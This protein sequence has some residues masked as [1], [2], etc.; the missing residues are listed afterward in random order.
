MRGL[1]ARSHLFTSTE[2]PVAGAV[3]RPPT[4]WHSVFSLCSRGGGRG[5]LS[6]SVTGAYIHMRHGN[7]ILKT[8]CV[9]LTQF[10]QSLL[11]DEGSFCHHAASITTRSPVKKHIN[12]SDLYCNGCLMSLFFFFPFRL[13]CSAPFVKRGKS[14]SQPFLTRE[15]QN[16]AGKVR[17]FKAQLTCSLFSLGAL[18]PT[19][20]TSCHRTVFFHPPFFFPSSDK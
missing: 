6:N 12:L 10:P 8:L 15:Q 4:R 11:V 7:P 14:L 13:R 2:K 9:P 5:L 19:S 1:D 17:Y 20:G 16:N 18:T 3:L